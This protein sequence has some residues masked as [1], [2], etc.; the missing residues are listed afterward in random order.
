[1]VSTA[2]KVDSQVRKPAT[3]KAAGVLPIIDDF[4]PVQN[5][6]SAGQTGSVQA[7][8]KDFLYQLKRS[9]SSSS[10]VRK[11]KAWWSNRENMAEFVAASVSRALVDELSPEVTLVADPK[12]HRVHVAS[13]FIS[14]NAN[15]IGQKGQQISHT[16]KQAFAELIALSALHGDHDVNTGNILEADRKLYRIDYGHAFNDLI[17]FKRFSGKKGANNPII[18][19]FNRERVGGL[20]RSSPSKLWRDYDPSMI[21][22]R[23]MADALEDMSGIAQLQK[24]QTGLNQAKEEYLKVDD[25]ATQR[26]IK[27]SLRAI[28]QTVSGSRLNM[29]EDYLKFLTQF[30]D[31]IDTF[32]QSNLVA[33]AQAAKIMHLQLD[34]ADNKQPLSIPTGLNEPIEWFK[35]SKKTKAFKGSIQE[36]QASITQHSPSARSS[37]S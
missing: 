24:I 22:S 6:P 30:F 36:Y 5:T 23:E 16:N 10:L 15:P 12:N 21:F 3:E 2:K 8:H 4:K 7:R 34:I 20:P 14:E 31:K 13:K 19:F 25:P 28:A 37:A 9:I 27:K 17:R 32:Y 26:K 1:M 11:I 33:M 29:N 35:T 18:D